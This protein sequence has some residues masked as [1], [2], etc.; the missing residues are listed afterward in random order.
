[1]ESYTYRVGLVRVVMEYY[2]VGLVVLYCRLGEGGGYRV[3]LVRVSDGVLCSRVGLVR[4]GCG[5][6]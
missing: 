4:V 2:T 3:G 1:M 5:E 6:L